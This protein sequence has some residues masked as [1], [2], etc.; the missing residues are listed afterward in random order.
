MKQDISVGKCV[1]SL[2]ELFKHKSSQEKNKQTSKIYIILKFTS[3][4]S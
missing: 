3:R 4:V 2:K 1:G